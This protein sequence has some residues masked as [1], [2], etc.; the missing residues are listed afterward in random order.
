MQNRVTALALVALFLAPSSWWAVSLEAQDEK[1][2]AYNLPQFLADYERSL[3]HIDSAFA[4]LASEGLPLRDESGKPLGRRNITDRRKTVADLRDAEKRA[5]ASPQDLVLALTLFSDNERLADDLYDLSQIAYDNDREEL[6]NRLTELLATV[7]H[8][9]DLI[10]SYV[11]NLAAEKQKTILAL[12]QENRE[13]Q[14]KLK[15]ATEKPKKG[16]PTR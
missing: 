14:Q 8:N 1:L 15:G 5:A 7:D 10:E 3:G 13:L 6:A 2:T 11:L 4:D 9:Q 16:P 12:Q